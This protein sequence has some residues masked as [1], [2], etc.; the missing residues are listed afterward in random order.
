MDIIENRYW[1]FTITDNEEMLLFA[2]VIKKL[3]ASEKKAG[4]KKIGLTTDEMD[5]IGELNMALH[6][7][8]GQE[9]NIDASHHA[10]IKDTGIE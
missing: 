1:T 10:N 6:G 3:H 5:L 7:D 2:S 8:N 4:F 9:V